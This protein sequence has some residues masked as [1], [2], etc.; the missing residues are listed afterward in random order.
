MLG[1]LI[2]LQQVRN[3]DRQQL[4][5]PHTNDSTIQRAHIAGFADSKG[6]LTQQGKKLM[7]FFSMKSTKKVD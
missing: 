6:H 4:F 5:T 3:A 1:R 2:A 7:N